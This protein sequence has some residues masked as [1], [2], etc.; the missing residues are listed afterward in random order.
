M[1]A[2]K[3]AAK[4]G[5]AHQQ[6]IILS[7]AATLSIPIALFAVMGYEINPAFALVPLIALAMV[8][9]SA[10]PLAIAFVA[11]TLCGLT[12]I[13]L[14]AYAAP[15]G[16]L[17]RDVLSLALLLFSA[18]FIFLGRL[19]AQHVGRVFYWL[20][21]MSSIFIIAVTA[22]LR[23]SASRRAGSRPICNIGFSMPRFSAC[24]YLASTAS[25]ASLT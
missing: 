22:R 12:S 25:T 1:I 13:T 3:L 16:R 23:F 19:M 10:S 4:A 20:A 21:V 7:V 2:A 18:S 15:D 14:A 17:L 6:S 5:I 11:S 24:R 8:R 9:Q